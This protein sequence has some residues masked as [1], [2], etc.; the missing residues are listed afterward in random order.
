MK[1]VELNLSNVLDKFETAMFSSTRDFEIAEACEFELFNKNE[2]KIYE[3]QF[4]RDERTYSIALCVFEGDD[5]YYSH[6]D[7]LETYS[8]D[9]YNREFL[10]SRIV[11]Y[12]NDTIKQKVH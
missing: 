3:L 6:E 8:M 5:G 4:D 11:S 2:D 1:L 12:M 10:I 9:Y 7:F